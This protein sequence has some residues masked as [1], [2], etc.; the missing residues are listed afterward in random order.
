MLAGSKHWGTLRAWLQVS[1]MAGMEVCKTA[2]ATEVAQH[3]GKVQQLGAFTV[4][5][6]SYVDWP[7]SVLPSAPV[8]PG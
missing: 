2:A 3:A 4:S 6:V 1:V 5:W 8:R 7:P